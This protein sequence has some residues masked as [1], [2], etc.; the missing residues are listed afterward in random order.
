[1]LHAAS[2]RKELILAA[3][4]LGAG[5]LVLPAAVYWVGQQ[6]VGD[7][8]GE[9]G[10]AGLI[11]QIWTDFVTFAPGAWVLVLSPYAIVSLLRI[12]LGTRRRAAD[13]TRVADSAESS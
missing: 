5:L 1:M 2:I 9:S 7:Y 8:E 12:A 13:V 4:L 11:G 10:L 3:G 6:I